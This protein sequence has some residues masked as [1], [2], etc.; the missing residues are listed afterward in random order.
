M[1]EYLA[2]LM[3][4]L[5]VD[6]RTLTDLGELYHEYSLF[7][8]AST[9]KGGIFPLNQ[10]CKA[11]IIS[12]YLQWAIAKARNHVDDEVTFAELFCADGYYAMLARHFGATS[13][14]GIDNDRDK[15]LENA[16]KIAERMK[17]TNIRFVKEDVSRIDSMAKVD[18]V[19]NVGGLYHVENPK[20]V[21]AKS[22]AMAR[23]YLIIQ[24]VVSLANSNPHYFETPAPGWTWGSRFNR[25]SFDNLIA[26]LGYKVLDRHFNELE[27]NDRPEDRGSVYYLIE[28]RQAPAASHA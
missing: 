20:E 17:I 6:P 22:Y 15:F 16:Q 26:S 13:S 19:A 12:A 25:E 28:V 1:K 7:G 10:R 23:K 3:R 5:N 14:T 18:I 24:N 9:Q 27:G 2:R 4:Y 21:L 8:Y 11:P